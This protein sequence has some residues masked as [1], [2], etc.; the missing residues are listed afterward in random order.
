MA[1]T[2]ITS[3]DSQLSEI[4]KKNLILEA[5]I[6]LFEDKENT[7]LF[8]N[9]FPS[10]SSQ[11]SPPIPASSPQHSSPVLRETVSSS[12]SSG[13]AMAQA[14][15]PQ[16]TNIP[17][18]TA[19]SANHPTLNTSESSHENSTCTPP[20]SPPGTPAATPCTPDNSCPCIQNTNQILIKVSD[21]ASRMEL[22]QT[23]LHQ[24]STGTGLPSQHWPPPEQQP[25]PQ[26]EPEHE[27]SR[28]PPHEPPHVELPLPD[29]IPPTHG[30]RSSSPPIGSSG[31]QEYNDEASNTPISG[32]TFGFDPFEPSEGPRENDTVQ[33]IDEEVEVIDNPSE[34]PEPHQDQVAPPHRRFLLPTPP[35]H[36]KLSWIKECACQQFG[37]PHQRSQKKRKRKPRAKKSS[38]NAHPPTPS[39]ELLIDL[40]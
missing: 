26:P 27:P 16:P 3:L 32:P 22:I 13:P 6:K 24:W 5:R 31:H 40:N 1:Q 35:P 25:E 36:L 39:E 7:T 12:P 14:S 17:P 18:A 28:E 19:S 9:Y 37:I 38:Q 2:K 11:C 29:P 23:V 30:E 20:P 4:Q 34:V 15:P 33:E 10:P 21:L 8:N